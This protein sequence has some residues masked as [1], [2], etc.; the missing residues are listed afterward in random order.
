MARDLV[1]FA[2]DNAHWKA[3]RK[4]VPW[5]KRLEMIEEEFP[6]TSTAGW[7]QILKDPDVLAR[8]L[9]DILKV[10]QIEVG[11][12]GPR[13]NLDVERG[14]RTWFEMSV[15]D[16]SELPF[17]ESFK[18]LV[19]GNSQRTIARKTSIS[20]TRIVRL[21]QG[22][23][24]PD[25][26]TLRVIAEAYQKRPAY[27]VEYRAEYILAAVAARL[28]DEHELTVALYRKLVQK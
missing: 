2:E 3:L 9:K 1:R 26:E 21:Q 7:A 13:P 8:V 10:D 24:R 11:R 14:M 17:V 18:V 4:R 16:Y 28:H 19:R 27:F 5:D 23:D 6:G 20:K 22:I 12:A 15:G 25:A